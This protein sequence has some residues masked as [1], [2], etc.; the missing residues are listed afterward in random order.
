[1]TVEHS[2][3]LIILTTHIFNLVYQLLDNVLGGAKTTVNLKKAVI[4]FH[5]YA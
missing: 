1:M 5:F 4:L 3:S 2:T